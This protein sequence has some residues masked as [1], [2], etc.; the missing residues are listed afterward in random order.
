MPPA[1]PAITLK[2]AAT[3]AGISVSTAGAVMLSAAQ[4]IAPWE[5]YYGR[6]YKDIV[7]VET[8]CYGQTAKA[9]VAEG[10]KRTLTKEECQKDL[11]DSLPLYFNGLMSCIDPAVRKKVPDSVLVS[12]LSLT[13]NVGPGAICHYTVKDG[14]RV[15]V[16]SAYVVKINA[17]DYAGAC[18][19][20]TAYNRAGGHVV[21]GLVNRRAAEEAYCLKGLHIVNGKT[22]S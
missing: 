1:R 20:L 13:Y 8:V 10:K 6:T 15:K 14:K 12:G 22:V 3:N 19:A 7:G 2:Q 9:L 4:L 5:G 17:G 11:A 16:D 21:K 18:R